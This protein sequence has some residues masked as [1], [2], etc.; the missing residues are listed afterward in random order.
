MNDDDDNNNNKVI[1]T[2]TIEITF[3]ADIKAQPLLEFARAR[4]I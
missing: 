2:R 3:G 4:L 1:I